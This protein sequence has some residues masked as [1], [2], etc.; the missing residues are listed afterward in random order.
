MPVQIQT[1]LPSY[2][3][4]SGELWRWQLTHC[5]ALSA[6]KVSPKKRAFMKR[7]KSFPLWVCTL[8]LVTWVYWIPS[9]P[10]GMEA[11]HETL[12]VRRNALYMRERRTETVAVQKPCRLSALVP[13]SAPCSL[14]PPT[15]NSPSDHKAVAEIDGREQMRDT[16]PPLVSPRH[17]AVQCE[18]KTNSTGNRNSTCPILTSYFTWS[19]PLF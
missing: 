12:L 6:I 15:P 8:G 5:S 17:V 16:S 13:D 10:S 14:E 3:R 4:R 1:S 7:G 9:A 19:C 18:G 2:Y 11:L